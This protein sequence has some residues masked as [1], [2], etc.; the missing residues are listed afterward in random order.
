[1]FQDAVC[2]LSDALLSRESEP[3]TKMTRSAAVLKRSVSRCR[4]SAAVPCSAAPV[5]APALRALA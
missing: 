5:E 4:R 2:S 1:M 3:R